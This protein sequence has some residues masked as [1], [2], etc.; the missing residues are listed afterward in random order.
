MANNAETVANALKS[1][2]NPAVPTPELDPES[3]QLLELF[4]EIDNPPEE[5]PSEEPAPAEP[6]VKEDGPDDPPVDTA[7]PP[8]PSPESGSSPDEPAP[9][10]SPLELEAPAIAPVPPTSEQTAATTA[11]EV[12]QRQEWRTDA[13]VKIEKHYATQL[14]GD[15]MRDMLLAEPEKALPKIF[16]NAYMDMYDSLLGGVTQSMPEQVRVVMSQQE[17]SAKDQADFFSR[18]PKLEEAYSGDTK[19]QKTINRTIQSYRVA[20]PNATMSEAIEEAGAMAMVA[21]RIPV[22]VS[23]KDTASPSKATKGFTPAS[24]GGGAQ[25]SSPAP[26]PKKL[27]EFETLAQELIDDDEV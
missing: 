9:E 5:T 23:E 24:P 12:K 11:E 4:E 8:E 21:L 20:N 13:L 7:S 15:E 17:K 16:A 10:A 3:A 6:S 26:A 18:W 25:H 2:D 27:N 14:E 22:E 19:K 1:E